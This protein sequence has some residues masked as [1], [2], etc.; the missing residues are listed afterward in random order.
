L[1]WDLVERTAAA[2]IRGFHSSRS[3]PWVGAACWSDDPAPTDLPCP[4]C[5]ARN[6]LA[7]GTTLP[8]RDGWRAPPFQVAGGSWKRR[9]LGWRPDQQPAIHHGDALGALARRV[10][11]RCS[12]DFTPSRVVAIMDH[13]TDART[14]RLVSGR[15]FSRF[16]QPRPQQRA[17]RRNAARRPT[18]QTGS[19]NY[20]QIPKQQ[21]HSNQFIH[22]R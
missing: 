17:S 22:R 19:D 14:S 16:M 12:R 10:E 11:W 8:L 20:R 3:R 7:L 13:A 18:R 9:R 15:F 21:P 6:A 4:S 5:D 1:S 2:H